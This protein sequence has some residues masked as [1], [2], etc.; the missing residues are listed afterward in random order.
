MAIPEGTRLFKGDVVSVEFLVEFD[1]ND[2]DEKVFLQHKNQ[3]IH[4]Q[5]H[6]DYVT[7]VRQN[8]QVGDRVQVTHGPPWFGVVEAVAGN[9]AWVRRDVV[10]ATVS[11]DCL[12]RLPQEPPPSPADTL[13]ASDGSYTFEFGEDVGRAAAEE[14]A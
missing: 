5:V 11:L 12:V 8:I 13:S 10:F 2:D 4:L 9:H 1:Q 7:L 14:V 3:Y 6:P